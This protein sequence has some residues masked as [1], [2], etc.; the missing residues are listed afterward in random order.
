MPGSHP[1]G[2]GADRG[3]DQGP[4]VRECEGVKVRAHVARRKIG[5]ALAP[6]QARG[7]GHQTGQR[8]RNRI[9][10]VF[11]WLKTVGMLRKVRHRGRERVDWIFVFAAAAYN[12]MRMTAATDA[13]EKVAD[14]V[15]RSKP[16]QRYIKAWF[17]T[18]GV[19][20]SLV[21]ISRVARR[22]GHFLTAVDV[23]SGGTKAVEVF[24]QCRGN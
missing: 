18:Q 12:L 23:A 20:T 3:Y 5:S 19:K 16:A 6:Q 9:E 21:E 14:V 4:F 11:G 7:K 8:K 24:R 10:E 2:C 13:I 15:R 1:I 22:L 17:K